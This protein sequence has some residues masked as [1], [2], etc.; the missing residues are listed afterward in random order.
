[1]MNVI[2]AFIQV[3]FMETGKPNRGYANGT[4]RNCPLLNHELYKLN[5]L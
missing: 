1:M 5:E 2:N 3:F 4:V